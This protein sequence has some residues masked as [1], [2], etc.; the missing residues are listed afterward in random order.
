MALK[1]FKTENFREVLCFL[2]LF[3]GVDAK[4]NLQELIKIQN[5]E[6]V[7]VRFSAQSLVKLK[8]ISKVKWTNLFILSRALQALSNGKIKY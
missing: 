4:E 5:E 1:L 3:E 8:C 6:K 2:M 7:S